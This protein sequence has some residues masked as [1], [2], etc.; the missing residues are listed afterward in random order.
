MRKRRSSQEDYWKSCWTNKADELLLSKKRKRN[1]LYQ[2]EF[3]TAANDLFSSDEEDDDDDSHDAAGYNQP[4][5][6]TEL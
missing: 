5:Q 6:T 2:G 1:D 4:T 3:V